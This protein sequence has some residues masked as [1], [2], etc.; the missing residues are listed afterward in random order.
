MG[1]NLSFFFI[2]IITA[3]CH[4]G[5]GAANSRRYMTLQAECTDNGLIVASLN[6]MEPFSGLIYSRNHPSSCRVAG[7]NASPTVLVMQDQACGFRVETR[8]GQAGVRE[9]DV[10]VQQD[11]LVQQVHI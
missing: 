9:V 6:T 1:R 2:V 11:S 4:M 7:D 3:M 10:Y 5:D 8:R